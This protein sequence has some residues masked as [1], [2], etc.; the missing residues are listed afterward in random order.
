MHFQYHPAL[1]LDIT[2][3]APIEVRQPSYN[4]YNKNQHRMLGKMTSGHFFDI[5]SRIMC[6]SFSTSILLTVRLPGLAIT[7]GLHANLWLASSSWLTMLSYRGKV[8]PSI[9]I[10]WRIWSWLC[11][12][13]SDSIACPRELKLDPVQRNRKMSVLSRIMSDISSQTRASG[14][15]C[16]V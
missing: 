1:L 15:R 6:W 4:L 3:S 16:L 5:V 11:I 9:M 14:V 7:Q 13:C 8:A 2:L 10:T 12:A